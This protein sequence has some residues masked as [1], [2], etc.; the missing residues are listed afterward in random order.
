MSGSVYCDY[1][2]CLA[3]LEGKRVNDRQ[4]FERFFEIISRGEA[5]EGESFDW[6]DDAKG[7]VSNTAVDVMAHFIS[8]YQMDTEADEIKHIASKML[9]NDPCNEEALQYLTKALLSQNNFK[10]AR[11]AYDGF[12]SEYHKAY[13]EEFKISFDELTTGAKVGD[14]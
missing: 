5:F 11:Y 9:V 10:Q 6:L 12:C 8:N 3:M 14:N 7:Y 2:Q 13:G 1:L 4:D